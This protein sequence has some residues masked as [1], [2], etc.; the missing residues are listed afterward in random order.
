MLE[1][2]LFTSSTL[3]EKTIMREI[4]VSLYTN[5]KESRVLGLLTGVGG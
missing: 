4:S 2:M 5:Y 3:H 1:N